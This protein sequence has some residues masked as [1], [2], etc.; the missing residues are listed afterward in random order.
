MCQSDAPAGRWRP[1]SETAVR[2][3]HSLVACIASVEAQLP[4][5][6]DV[7]SRAGVTCFLRVLAALADAQLSPG[8]G[9]WR[10]LNMMREAVIVNSVNMT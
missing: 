1:L 5:V 4:L 10:T 2:E 6:A 8:A 7:A 9:E 3:A